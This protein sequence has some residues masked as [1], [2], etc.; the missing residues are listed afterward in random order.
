MDI[1]IQVVKENV[2]LR[3]LYRLWSKTGPFKHHKA[4]TLQVG[5]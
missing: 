4:V 3:E 1:A 2:A 5:R